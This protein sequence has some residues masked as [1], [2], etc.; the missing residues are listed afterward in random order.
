VAPD[1]DALPYRTEVL[2]FL[3]REK[4]RGRRLVLATAA[5]LAWAL[6]IAGSLDLFDAVLAS[7]G[8]QNLKG[9]AK[10]KAIREYC[11]QHGFTEFAYIG[12]ARAD[13]PI[14]QA[15]SEA[16]VV[17][18]T[19]SLERAIRARGR[20]PQVL[21]FRQAWLRSLL[22]A[23]RPH[24]SAKNLL[25][26]IPLLLA[27]QVQVFEKLVAVLVAFAAFSACAS[28]V[29][30][31][32]DLLDLEADRKHPTK[33][34]RPFASGALH[35]GVGPP[36][37]LLLIGF[38]FLLTRVVLPPDF[39]LV[40]LFY[41]VLTG[42]YCFWLK[43]EVIADVL[44]LA[45]LYTTRIVA[46][47]VA[48]GVAVSEWLLAFA[49]FFFTSLAFLKRYAEL[50]DTG[51]GGRAGLLGRGYIVTDLGLIESIGA[52]SGCLAVLVFALYTSSADVSKLYARP[53]VL[54]LIGPLLLYWLGRVWFMARRGNL[55]DD[56]VLFALKDR[57]SLLLGAL[58]GILAFL[59]S[60]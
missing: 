42:T 35:L 40:L 12:D 13:L 7:D 60:V 46:G 16:Y 45:G 23:L 19:A 14:W 29:Y 21:S 49:M 47:G 11:E 8:H 48:G 1:P 9:Q 56:P 57:V 18:A 25:L 34:D 55:G 15:A 10:L 41:L 54:W 28:G 32:N 52:S 5:D 36:A 51:K 30:L 37:A 38:A 59:A 31:I 22:L 44:V 2:E 53:K 39:A 43:G 20:T 17:T 4:A 58:I 26:F 3:Q 27:H 50:G 33:R 24:Q 6:G